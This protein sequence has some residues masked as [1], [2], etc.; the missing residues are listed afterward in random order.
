VSEKLFQEIP[1]DKRKADPCDK[2][3]EFIRHQKLSEKLGAD[4][5]FATLYHSWESGIKRASR[6][7]D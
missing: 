3:K 7:M 2:I 1:F 6:L 4:F 5:Y